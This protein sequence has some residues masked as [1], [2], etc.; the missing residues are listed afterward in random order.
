M[1]V[2]GQ[3][4]IEEDLADAVVARVVRDA[5]DVAIYGFDG[6]V[7]RVA[8]VMD[9][10]PQ[11]I[12]YDFIAGCDGHHGVIRAQAA[13]SRARLNPTTLRPL[14]ELPTVLQSGRVRI[15][16]HTNDHRPVHVH[17]WEARRQAMFNLNERA[18][19]AHDR[20]GLQRIAN[21]TPPD[22]RPT[23]HRDRRVGK[24][25]RMGLTAHPLSF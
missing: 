11:E 17:A 2:Y 3:T 4:E 15:T 24:L 18:V 19:K 22:Q 6:S 8:Y 7:P 21:L 16:I 20:R 12:R 10:V 9:G 13:D 14:Y 5:N 25:Q 23:T 1:L